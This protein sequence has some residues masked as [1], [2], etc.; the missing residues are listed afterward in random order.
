M[1]AKELGEMVVRS[2]H[3]ALLCLSQIDPY[4]NFKFRLVWKGNVVAGVAKVSAL[5]TRGAITGGAKPLPQAA[6]EPITFERGVTHDESF[7]TWARQFSAPGRIGGVEGVIPQFKRNFFLEMYDEGGRRSARDGI[8]SDRATNHSGRSA[9]S[10]GKRV[11]QT[12]N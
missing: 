11:S 9:R 5:K 6:F 10:P 12:I 4:R 7:V 8:S 1:S 3:R 2:H